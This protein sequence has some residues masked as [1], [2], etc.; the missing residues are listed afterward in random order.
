MTASVTDSSGY[1]VWEPQKDLKTGKIYWTNHALQNTVWETPKGST[2]VKQTGVVLTVA[3]AVDGAP[4]TS[5]W[6]QQTTGAWGQEAEW[7]QQPATSA[8]VPVCCTHRR[9]RG[10]WARGKY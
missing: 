6:G 7:G 10:P 2:T 5:A 4:E 3:P 8:A 9:L 1:G